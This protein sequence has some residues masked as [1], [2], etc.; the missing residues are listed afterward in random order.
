M[1]AFDSRQTNEQCL[2]CDQ[3]TK[4]LFC[5]QWILIYIGV[6]RYH[7]V[8]K[9]QNG[10]MRWIS[11]ITLRIVKKWPR[12]GNTRGFGQGAPFERSL[13][14]LLER[15]SRD[16]LIP[17]Y[18]WTCRCQYNIYILVCCLVYCFCGLIVAIWLALDTHGTIV[19]TGQGY[20]IY[21]RQ[22]TR[23]PVYVGPSR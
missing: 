7:N 1:I 19:L 5:R 16:T 17:G 18:V 23:V 11:H 4:P 3:T 8:K 10:N 22:Y 9:S 15:V 21:L 12:N 2:W 14:A 13:R 20:Q 6:C